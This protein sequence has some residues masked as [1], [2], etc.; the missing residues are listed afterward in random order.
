VF[1]G[2]GGNSP[3]LQ[4]K[5]NGALSVHGAPF[6]NMTVASNYFAGPNVH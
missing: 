3:P 6:R 5:R 1:S 4:D 2:Y